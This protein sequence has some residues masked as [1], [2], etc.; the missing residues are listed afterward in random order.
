MSSQAKDQAVIES[1]LRKA[2]ERLTKDEMSMLVSDLFIQTD[3][4]SGEISLYSEDKE[5]IDK[6][7]IFNWVNKASDKPAFDK[8]ATETT[9]AALAALNGQ[10][11]FEHDNFL[12]PFSIS[13][14]DENFQVLEELLFIDDDI[15]RLDDPLLKDLDQDL[16]DFL[17]Q[18]LS[19]V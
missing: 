19:D 14:T 5:L 1:F 13:M 16:S 15:L 9:K 3:A 18:L 2:I 12:K 6:T 7:V 4:E 17:E 8:I 10:G 11:H